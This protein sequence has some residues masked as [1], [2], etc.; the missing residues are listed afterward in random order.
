MT[1][2][3][4]V[5]ALLLGSAVTFAPRLV[6]A[7]QPP[8]AGQ[9]HNYKKELGVTDAQDA[10]IKSIN[11]KYNDKAKAIDLQV[12]QL[13]ADANKEYEALLTP[14]QLKKAK[15]IQLK[16]KQKQDALVKQI[17]D[18]QVQGGKEVDAVFTA[19]QIKKIQQIQ[20]EQLKAAQQQQAPSAPAPK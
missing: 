17:E 4:L 6:Q 18:L 7:Q 10:K 19:E 3:V 15:A 11:R 14:A 1:R 16:Y 9:T 5:T 13:P 12:R 2:C 20:Q 8:A